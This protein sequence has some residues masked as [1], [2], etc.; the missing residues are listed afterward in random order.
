[1]HNKGDGTIKNFTTLLGINNQGYGEYLNGVLQTGQR[2]SVNKN[3]MKSH[4]NGIQEAV[5]IY[6]TKIKISVLTGFDQWKNKLNRAERRLNE[7]RKEIETLKQKNI[8]LDNVRFFRG[9]LYSLMGLIFFLGE[10]E[11]SKQTI[12]YAMQMANISIW[13]QAAL[14]LALASTTGLCKLVYE[15]FLEP[16]YDE[17]KENAHKS[18]IRSFFFILTGFIVILFIVIAYYRAVIA[19]ILLLELDNP[20]SV[21]SSDHAFVMVSVYVVIALL[22]LVGSAILLPVGLKEL[23][24]YYKIK[25]NKSLLIKLSIEEANTEKYKDECFKQYNEHKHTLDFINNEKDF[26]TYLQSEIQF[27][28]TQYQRGILKGVD[29]IDIKDNQQELEKNKESKEKE[30]ALKTNSVHEESHSMND[31]HL[32]IRSNL[33][34]A[35]ELN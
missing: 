22:F 15:R 27:F 9:F 20:Y 10:V 31:F 33:D 5:S 29:K 30:T 18:S 17:T 2:D 32:R 19:K 21:L 26:N 34:K 28:N 4:S 16:Y 1:M 35:A 23:S 7:L 6:Y 12:I 11:F 25:K 8:S 24:N 3:F 14:V 13:W